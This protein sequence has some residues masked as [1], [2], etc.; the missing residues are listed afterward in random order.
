[1]NID[2]KGYYDGWVRPGSDLCYHLNGSSI[3]VL[4]YDD[5][6]EA[7][8]DAY[9]EFVTVHRLFGGDNEILKKL[10]NTIM[11]EAYY[12]AALFWNGN[13]GTEMIPSY[14]CWIV[15][16][17]TTIFKYVKK[18]F[19]FKEDEVKVNLINQ[20]IKEANKIIES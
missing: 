19:V 5:L 4:G 17:R 13:G 14:K 20:I 8:W 10:N 7:L 6:H 12:Y 1:M 16:L 2:C 18:G 9:C 11:G 15:E 3:A